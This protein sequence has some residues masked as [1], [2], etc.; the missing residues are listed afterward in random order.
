MEENIKKP[1]PLR[2]LIR[3][4]DEKTRI[5]DSKY[6]Y[7]YPNENKGIA[8]EYNNFE[9]TQFEIPL[10]ELFENDT[11]ISNCREGIKG[12]LIYIKNRLECEDYKESEKETFV[13]TIGKLNELLTLFST[14][15]D[16]FLR[17][18]KILKVL[19]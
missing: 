11:D 7:Y 4:K 18:M 14:S 1:I 10:S 9:D 2:N 6:F 13:K 12:R 15:Y 16:M 3:V 8:I 19:D 5:G 17:K